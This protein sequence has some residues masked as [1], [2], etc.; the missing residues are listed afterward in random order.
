MIF[1]GLIR[2]YRIIAL[3]ILIEMISIILVF[4]DSAGN[5]CLS[6]VKVFSFILS[7]LS[8]FRGMGER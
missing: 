4:E 7:K 6:S 5:D 2:K 1:D 3:G 8:V